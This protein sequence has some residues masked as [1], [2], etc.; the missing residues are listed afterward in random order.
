VARFA[1]FV[2][3]DRRERTDGEP[4]LPLGAEAALWS[5]VEAVPHPRNHLALTRDLSGEVRLTDGERA[6]INAAFDSYVAGAAVA[7]MVEPDESVVDVR[8]RVVV[9][10]DS[11]YD[12]G[13]I[14]EN[15]PL[16]DNLFTTA[17]R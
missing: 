5:I 10:I 7:T 1:R 6:E 14:N 15:A 2:T 16:T 9:T 13:V 12:L 11:R 8:D 17:E 4:K 3:R